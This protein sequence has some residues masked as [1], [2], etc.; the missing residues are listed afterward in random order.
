MLKL[1]ELPPRQWQEGATSVIRGK[2]S[3]GINDMLIGSE[4]EPPTGVEGK[5]AISYNW[6]GKDARGGQNSKLTRVS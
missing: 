6:C 3:R 2:V 5:R 4:T 1:S